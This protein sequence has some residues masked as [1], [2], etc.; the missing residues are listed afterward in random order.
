[1][2]TTD[3]IRSNLRAASFGLALAVITLLFGQGIGIVFGL[4]ED[5]IKGRLKESATAVRDTVYKADDA[6][7]KA[8]L[9]KSWAYMQRA[10]LHAGGMGTSAAVLT[11]LVCVLEIS[12]RVVAAIGIGLGA[13]GLGYSLYWMWAGFRAPILGGTSAAKESLAWLAVPASGAFVLATFA[14]LVVLLTRF[15]PFRP[16]ANPG[17]SKPQA[18]GRLIGRTL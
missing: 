8:V 17:E 18:A 14:V 2:N 3:A 16:R 1:M 15:I 12:R 11:T 5:T 4:N 13:G 6:A 10:H 9:D 7:I